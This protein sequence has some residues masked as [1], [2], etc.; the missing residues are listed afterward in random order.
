MKFDKEE[1][2]H[3]EW[4]TTK[5]NWVSLQTKRADYAKMQKFK[6]KQ[7]KKIDKERSRIMKMH[8]WDEAKKQKIESM[9]QQFFQL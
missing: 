5:A 1:R 4:K 9:A 2:A 7:A 8:T 6:G 3:P